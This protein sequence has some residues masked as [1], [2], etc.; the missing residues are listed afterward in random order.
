MAGLRGTRNN[1]SVG[2]TFNSLVWKDE[3]KVTS[4]YVDLISAESD[5][6]VLQVVQP[7]QAGFIPKQAV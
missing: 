3:W 4:D 1:E 6:P 2:A 7:S 5:Q